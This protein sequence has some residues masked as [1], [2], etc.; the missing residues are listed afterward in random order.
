MTFIISILVLI[1]YIMGI[2]LN[3]V[4]HTRLL[5]ITGIFLLFRWFTN[6]RK[7]TFSY[8]E[9]KLR[10]VKK[11]EGIIYNILEPIYDI[12]QEPYR[13]IY[14]FIIV[15]IILYINPTLKLY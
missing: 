5:T 1:F 14:Y 6:M 13:Y 2:F 8:I 10:D 15:A 11:E 3:N 12:N 7:C 4:K 9:C